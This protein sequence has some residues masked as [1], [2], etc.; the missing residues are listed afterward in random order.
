[1]RMRPSRRLQAARRLFLTGMLVLTAGGS[2]C[3]GNYRVTSA[4]NLFTYERPF[5]DASAEVVRTDADTLCRD[6]R[7]VAIRVSDV[8]DMT[9]CFTNYQCVGKEEVQQLVR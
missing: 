7:M 6:R 3:T 1:M 2:N 8:C 4:G 9:R 5:T